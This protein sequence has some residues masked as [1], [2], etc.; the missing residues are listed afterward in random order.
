MR[1]LN[2]IMQR[3][4][5]FCPHCHQELWI[6]SVSSRAD[7]LFCK[8]VDCFRYYERNR[9]TKELT[10]LGSFQVVLD[11][12]QSKGLEQWPGSPT[13]YFYSPKLLRMVWDKR[14]R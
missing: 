3:H 11:Y 10:E 8:N 7:M 12:M 5:V 13:G 6:D 2:K 1:I 14:N 4:A 9:K